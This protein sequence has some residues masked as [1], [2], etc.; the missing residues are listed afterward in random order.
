MF[1]RWIYYNFR[2]LAVVL[3]VVAGFYFFMINNKKKIG[4]VDASDDES[5]DE[6][7]V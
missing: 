4:T 7:D 5:I 3:A 1:K 2:A 6:T